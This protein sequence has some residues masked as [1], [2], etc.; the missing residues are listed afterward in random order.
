MENFMLDYRIET[1][2]KVCETR[3]YRK[4]AEQL[5]M[6][7]PAVT[8]HIQYLESLYQTKFFQYK[9]KKLSLTEKGRQ[10]EQHARSVMYNELQFRQLMKQEPIQ[11]IRIGATKTIGDYVIF[12]LLKPYLT[13]KTYQ[14]TLTI[15]NTKHLLEQL[16]NQQ[17]DFLIVEGY[18]D[19]GRYD[20]ELLKEEAFTGI[21]SIYHPFANK[22]IPL[23]QIFREHLIIREQGSGTRK[24]FENFLEEYNYGIHHFKKTTTINSLHIIEKMVEEN[25]GISFVYESIPRQNSKLAMFQI[26][27]QQLKHEFNYVFLKQSSAK[28]IFHTLQKKS[29]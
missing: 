5:N 11:Q 27:G 26:K 7:Q 23:E 25:L 6:T 19:K 29:D 10:F 12:D 8:Q 16:D 17:L 4:A 14:F 24:V 20:Y 18:F 1:F 15:D 21:C 9:N 22:T 28:K 2:L 13:S 3:N